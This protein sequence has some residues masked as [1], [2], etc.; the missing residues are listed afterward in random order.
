MMSYKYGEKSNEQKK[1]EQLNENGAHIE[2]MSAQKFIELL[3][4]PAGDD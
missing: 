4:Q 3:N 2:I 1:A